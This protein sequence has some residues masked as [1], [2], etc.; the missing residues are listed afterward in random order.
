MSHAILIEDVP[1]GKAEW[2][3]LETCPDCDREILLARHEGAGRPVR[4]EPMPVLVGARNCTPCKGR[5]T[6]HIPQPAQAGPRRSVEPG[7]LAGRTTNSRGSGTRTSCPECGGTG[8]RGEEL[9]S[10]HVVMRVD[11]VV[12][13]HPRLVQAWDSA[14]RRHSC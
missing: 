6:A 3:R 7:D 10:E 2:P 12:R 5:G 13:E 4:L 1:M 11:G 9:T 14:Y 8:L